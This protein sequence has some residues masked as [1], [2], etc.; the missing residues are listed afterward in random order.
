MA[1]TA[2]ACDDRPELCDHCRATA[3]ELAA[4]VAEMC[5]HTRASAVNEIEYSDPFT[6]VVSTLRRRGPGDWYVADVRRMGNIERARCRPSAG[7]A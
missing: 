7:S 2:C 4:A 1:E 5:E 6:G 3:I